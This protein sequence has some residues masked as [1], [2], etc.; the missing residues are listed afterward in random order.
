MSKMRKIISGPGLTKTRPVPVEFQP[1]RDKGR[2]DVGRQIQQL[3][4]SI[5]KNL[6]QVCLA[7]KAGQL[8]KAAMLCN[9]VAV[10]RGHIMGLA[11]KLSDSLAMEHLPEAEPLERKPRYRSQAKVKQFSRWSEV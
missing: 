2:Q 10:K 3:K 8:D 7:V 1:A 4:A 11:S 9:L 6:K 5:E